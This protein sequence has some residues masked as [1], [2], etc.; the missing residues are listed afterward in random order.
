MASVEGILEKCDRVLANHTSGVEALGPCD[1]G[2]AVDRSLQDWEREGEA[3]L[4]LSITPDSDLML[5]H[6]TN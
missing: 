5:V 2:T 3:E 6:C 4:D 1:E